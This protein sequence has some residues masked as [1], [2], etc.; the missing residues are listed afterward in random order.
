MGRGADVDEEASPMSQLAGGGER[1]TA[2]SRARRCRACADGVGDER[3]WWGPPLVRP[4]PAGVLLRRDGADA[5]PLLLIVAAGCAAATPASPSSP[6]S[7]ATAAAP[8]RHRSV[9]GHT[10]IARRS[11]AEGGGG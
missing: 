10:L 3:G 11:Y 6:T 1:R 7:T 5:A 8:R 2:G 4:P 9:A